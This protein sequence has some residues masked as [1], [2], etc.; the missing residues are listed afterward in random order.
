[1]NDWKE[2]ATDVYVR[3]HASFDVNCGLVL[4]DGEGLLVDT[5]SWRSEAEDLRASIQSVTGV[6]VRHVVNTHGHFDH[7]FGNE[8]FS[9]HAKVWGQRRCV[10]ELVNYGEMQRS[11]ML[12]LLPERRDDLAAVHIVPPNELVDEWTE[13]AVGGR[14]V[15]LIH[16]GRGHTDHDLVVSVAGTGVLFAGDL[17]EESGPPSFNDSWPTEW[18][19]TVAR[20]HEQ[21]GSVYVPGHG[22][23]MTPRA[24]EQQTEEL[25]TLAA[26]LVDCLHGILGEEALI[27]ASPFPKAPTTVAIQRARET[28]APQPRL[29]CNGSIA[30]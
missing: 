24:V 16:F 2:V 29:G 6:P 21:G 4:G 10:D 8:I 19:E 30:R 11:V 20:L 14:T 15:Q 9:G 17:I 13:I 7:C 18:P 5:R 12:E 23:P 27:R 25:R 1:M 28:A 22:E 26:L 3:R